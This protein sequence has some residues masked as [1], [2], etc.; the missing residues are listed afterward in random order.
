MTGGVHDD[1]GLVA[2]VV[3][4]RRIVLVRTAGKV[5]AVGGNCKIIRIVVVC[6]NQRFL[7]TVFRQRDTADDS[8]CFCT[9][10]V[11]VRHERAECVVTHYNACVVE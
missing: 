2:V 10:D 9:D 6:I 3:L 8:G 7:Q 11:V 1:A 4:P 5:H